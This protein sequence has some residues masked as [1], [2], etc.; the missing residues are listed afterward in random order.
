MPNSNAPTG[1]K[2]VRYRNGAPWTGAARHYHV[3][4]ANATALF[5][6]DPVIITGTGDPAGYPDAGIATAAGAGRITGVIVGIRP[7]APFS[8]YKH[9][10]ASTE[11]YIIVADDP[12]LLFEAQEDSVGGALA[13]TN[14]GQNIDLIA[15][16]GNTGTG[17][18]GWQL[19]SSTAATTAT[20]QCR[21]IELQHTPDN[22]IGT[23]AKWLVAINLP[24]ETGAAGST[25]V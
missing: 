6:G 4:A 8:P 15:G 10:P 16:A 12:A 21:L 11:G 14:I 20:L 1:L 9:L 23:N 19:D 17:A 25:G 24:T 7:S 5:V 2:P 18:S 13:A 3:P 22:D